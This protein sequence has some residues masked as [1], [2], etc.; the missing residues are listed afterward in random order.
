MVD[1][2]LGGTELR[3]VFHWQGQ[4]QFTKSEISRII[5]GACG[6]PDSG[7]TAGGWVPTAEDSRLDCS[8]LSNLFSSMKIQ[9]SSTSLREGLRICLSPFH[10]RDLNSPPK[11]IAMPRAETTAALQKVSQQAK[12]RIEAVVRLGGG[13]LSGLSGNFPSAMQD[14]ST[15][16][17][18][19]PAATLDVDYEAADTATTAVVAAA[20]EVPA[21][22]SSAA[23]RVPEMYTIHSVEAAPALPDTGHDIVDRACRPHNQVLSQSPAVTPDK[24]SINKALL[25]TKANLANPREDTQAAKAS[26]G[27]GRE[28]KHANRAAALK[29]VFREELELAWRRYRDASYDGRSEEEP[30]SD[31]Q[32]GWAFLDK[33]ENQHGTI[34]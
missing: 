18:S 31:K 25:A 6:F 2:H 7:A 1:L 23:S 22:A 10:G 4:E 3:G 32:A 20:P 34:V 15:G 19:Y 14:G 30:I 11:Q 24:R 13:E 9:T 26:S 5:S 21:A 27:G 33:K 28:D 12:A 16:G 8:R 17:S 29:N